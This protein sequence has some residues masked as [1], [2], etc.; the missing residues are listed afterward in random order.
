MIVSVKP[1]AFWNSGC[2][3]IRVK[4]E[5]TEETEFLFSVSSYSKSPTEESCA[6]PGGASAPKREPC[7]RRN[8]PLALPRA[9]VICG[10]LHSGTR[11][12]KN[13]PAAKVWP[14]LGT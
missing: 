12:R 5:R 9:C 13:H 4:Q 2:I 14:A 8:G 6:P 10:R 11:P 7:V 3:G 1:E